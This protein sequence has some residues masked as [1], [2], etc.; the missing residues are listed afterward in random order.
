MKTALLALVFWFGG[1]TGWAQTNSMKLC[2]QESTA[3]CMLIKAPASASLS[4][5]PVMMWGHGGAVMFGLSDTTLGVL[6]GDVIAGGS[7]ISTSDPVNASVMS[8]AATPFSSAGPG[9]DVSVGKTGTGT[10]LPLRFFRN[11]NEMARFDAATGHE[12][13]LLLGI[14]SSDVNTAIGSIVTSDSI[15]NV[16]AAAN[17]SVLSLRAVA[18]TYAAISSSH[19]GSG[20][21]LPMAFFT[22]S[23]ERFRIR[24]DGVSLFGLASTDVSALAGGIVSANSLVSVT[25]T[26]NASVGSFA[27]VSGNYV[28][29]SSSKTGSGTILPM[30]F[31]VGA[32]ERIRITTG[33]DIAAASA[34]SVGTTTGPFGDSYFTG[35]T[36][37]IRFRM[38]RGT[39]ASVTSYFDWMNNP[40]NNNVLE[41]RDSSNVTILQVDDTH[42]LV[43][44]PSFIFGGRV[45]PDTTATYDLGLSSK[46]WNT[47]YFANLNVSGTCTG[48]GTSQWITTGSD[49]YYNTGNVGIG[50]VSPGATLDV[51]GSLLVQTALFRAASGTTTIQIQDGV[52]TTTTAIAQ[53]STL[54]KFSN[55]GAIPIEFDA[56]T[57]NGTTGQLFLAITG[58]VG[59][60]TTSPNFAVSLGAAVTS[61]K[62][63]V[64]DS[65]GDFLGFGVASGI[66]R[67]DS[68]AGS[69]HV[70]YTAS[71]TERARIQS[72]G[73]LL[74]GLASTDLSLVAGTVVSASS[75]ISVTATTNA[76]VGSFAAIASNYVAVSS[77]KTG[78]GT[79]LPLTFW[80]SNAERLRIEIG[81]II[82]S[83]LTST[84]VSVSAGAIVSANSL[85]SVTASTNATVG[86][87][88]AIAGNYV[89]IASS[90]TGSG[91][92]QPLA[93]FTSSA[94]RMRI[95]TGGVSLFGISST[96]VSVS[97]GAIVSGNSIVSVTATTNATVGSFAAV[98]GNY[99][100]IAS[101]KTGSGTYQP[102]AF[103][104]SAT[105]RLR[106]LTNGIVAVNST[107]DNGSG[108][109]FQVGGDISL[110][111]IFKQGT[112]TRLTS[113]GVLTVA[114]I[115]ESGL[116]GQFD[117]DG[118]SSSNGKIFLKPGNV[119]GLASVEINGRSG[120]TKETA[121]LIVNDVGGSAGAG[122]SV[123]HGGTFDALWQ[124]GSTTAFDIVS[125]S[126]VH[127]LTILQNG[128]VLVN[129]TSDDGSG[130]FFQVNG[131]ISFSGNMIHAGTTGLSST[132]TVR[133]SAGTGT[134]TITIAGGIVTG[135]TC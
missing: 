98:A 39:P 49:I 40:S 112:V 69:D 94:E 24:V 86:S 41:L 121:G 4:P 120:G 52:P 76:S 92:Y 58:A 6:P 82:L 47:G 99:V 83:G 134:C 70:F 7:F 80:T 66:L 33:G 95:D 87:F 128:A 36:E 14:T 65:G 29:I 42:V 38:Y 110:S 79:Y 116:G 71:G 3:H 17:A 20:S 25:A 50:T 68:G 62:L 123:K 75:L 117:I 63:A 61:Q 23:T 27:A 97:A 81:G 30:A 78:S 126:S 5:S 10:L 19:T 125:N 46:R 22:Q 64:Y 31:F 119:S 16:T 103:F 74:V 96:D 130:A 51:A 44:Y 54:L 129:R 104:T 11:P 34:T 32:S 111:G 55:N 135:S 73:N 108:A 60:G 45:F 113:A 114:S 133:N 131:N 72:A 84:D 12:N 26:S 102:M 106:I 93:F 90:K 57:N 88:G 107:S 53:S 37:S 18:S 89:A 35:V 101:S 1:Q 127:V 67:Y 100:A 85:V 15:V 122:I 115:D 132:F 21:D 9:A 43:A 56:F 48:C 2:T 77:G 109:F 105:E 91:T 13:R 8:F 59:M 28:A 118:S 124:A